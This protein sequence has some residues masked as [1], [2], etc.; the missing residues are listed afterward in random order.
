MWLDDFLFDG[1]IGEFLNGKEFDLWSDGFGL[2]HV[3]E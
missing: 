1:E 3:K 2:C